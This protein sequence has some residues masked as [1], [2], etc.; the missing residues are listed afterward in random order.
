MLKESGIIAPIQGGFNT[1]ER[2][3]SAMFLSEYN[4][5]LGFL[6]DGFFTDG[7]IIEEIP[8]DEIIPVVKQ[9]MVLIVNAYIY[10]QW[11]LIL[12][13]VKIYFW[14]EIKEYLP[15]DKMKVIFGAWTPSLII[16]FI[17][18][19]VDMFDTSFPYLSTERKSALVFDYNLKYK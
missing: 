11:I 6:F 1:H 18:N 9:T 2:I 12:Y 5:V 15:N 3:R 7:S 14:F 16:D 4:E 17:N 19:G 10:F 13:L 8:S